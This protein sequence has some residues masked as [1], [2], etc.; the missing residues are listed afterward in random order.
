MSPGQW[1]ISPVYHCR[2]KL[3]TGFTQIS[4]DGTGKY[5]FWQQCLL[6]HKILAPNVAI[7]YLKYTL[8]YWVALHPIKSFLFNFRSNKSSFK[9][10]QLALPMEHRKQAGINSN[11]QD[12]VNKMLW[13]NLKQN[14]E[15]NL[16]FS[17]NMVLNGC[18]I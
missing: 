15:S 5:P 6:L 1:A 18:S 10:A 12:I 17:Q 8:K 9:F 13:W 16:Q 3:S 14:F 7:N 2:G 4:N 11:K